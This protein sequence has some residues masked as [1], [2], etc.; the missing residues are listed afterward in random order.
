M[1][2]YHSIIT[3]ISLIFALALLGIGAIFFSLFMHERES[4]LRQMNDYAHIALRSAMDPHTRQLD[5]SKLEELGF[6]IINDK[7]LI[8]KLLTLP[9]PPRPL[10][11][12]HMEEKMRFRIDVIPYGIHMFA[13]LHKKDMHPLVVQL[14]YQKELFPRL[15]F[16]LLTFAFVIFLYIG[17]L[18]SIMPLKTLREQIK[19]FA[20]GNYDVTCKSHKKDEIA[21]LANEF[22][23]A[24]NKIKSLRDSRQLFLRNIMHELK[25]PITK[26]KLASEMI[27][28]ATYAKILQNVFK[29]QEALLEEFSR[30]EKLSADELKLEIKEYHIED[31]VD[32][33]LDI[34]EDK[35]EHI[36]CKLSP[37]EISVDFELFGVALKNLLD[38][39]I[40]YASDGKVY[41][42]NDQ[43]TIT[44]SNR[45]PKLEFALERYAEPYFL[46]GKKQ[47]SSRGLGFGL[48]ITWH[49]IRLHG[50]K[51]AYTH[52]EGMNHFTISL[53]SV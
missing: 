7:A 35:K 22:D 53:K 39:G 26:G 11:M 13:M 16:P 45:A 46:E 6:S 32:F 41:L 14:P 40:N 43:N 29:R 44:I 9:K 15:L 3:R 5:Q 52:K 8:E 25:T 19:H 48:F 10:P 23:L 42:E 33:A 24:V 31:V 27:E 21:T 20:N 2:W 49:V 17:I 38:N 47:K 4:T 18:R 50:M 30:I 51:L 28:D 1:K 12:R 34:L 36:T 37:I